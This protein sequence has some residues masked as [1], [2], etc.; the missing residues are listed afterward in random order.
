MRTII[1]RVL[2]ILGCILS[3]V[4]YAFCSRAM[5]QSSCP[6]GQNCP[7]PPVWAQVGTFGRVTA[8]Q[9]TVTVRG[10]L[11]GASVR[12]PMTTVARTASVVP[13]YF[14]ES[15]KIPG[16]GIYVGVIR[17]RGVTITAW[18]AAKYGVRRVLGKIPLGLTKCKLGYDLAAVLTDPLDVPVAVL[19]SEARRGEAVVITGYPR[20]RVGSRRTRVIKFFLPEAGQAWGDLM[21]EGSSV[22]GDS[23]GAVT[24]QNNQLVGM[25]YGTVDGDDTLGNVSAAVSVTAIA[26]FLRRVD[27]MLG[28]MDENGDGAAEPDGASVPG[29]PVTPPVPS[30]S[31]SGRVISDGKQDTLPDV[32]TR[33]SGGSDNIISG[34]GSMAIARPGVGGDG[35]IP[36]GV[37]DRFDRLEALIAANAAAIHALTLSA[38]KEG[39]RGE[40]GKS[41]TIDYDILAAEVAGK[42]PPMTFEMTNR[43]GSITTILGRLGG[44]PVSLELVPVERK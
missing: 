1:F 15:D 14:G 29:L 24:D 2:V 26:D 30:D 36:S 17:G 44:A 39:K 7:T 23:G 5:G 27:V 33:P 22:A 40:A 41:P 4:L 38:P 10:G 31:P 16:A 34:D 3:I 35:A 6:P 19:A 13:V 8:S 28:E 9:G 21:L 20:G 43:D 37:A 42:L 11:G 25:L 18:H 32:I 12:I